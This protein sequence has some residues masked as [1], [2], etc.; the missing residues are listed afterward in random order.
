M[1]VEY[2]YMIS[3]NKI[4]EVLDAMQKAAKPEPRMSYQTLKDWGFNSSNDRAIIPLFKRLGVLDPNGT[5]SELYDDLK[6]P[7]TRAVALARAIRESYSEIFSINTK[8]YEAPDQEVKAALSRVTGKDEKT[9][10]RYF[11][12]LSR[13]FGLADFKSSK[14]DVESQ[15][16]Q[17]ATEKSDVQKD[18]TN[19]QSY[20]DLNKKKRTNEFHYNIQIHLPATTD[21][22]VYNA[23]FKALKDNLDVE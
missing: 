19:Q 6:D 9:V 3:N 12:T 20:V 15:K 22:T 23:I 4:S 16:N 18:A 10:D 11:S 8:I 7:N 14:L 1:S 2:S 5:P 13:L 17:A 21:I